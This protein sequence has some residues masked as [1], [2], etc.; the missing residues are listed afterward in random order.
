MISIA[1]I[2]T[3]DAMTH[4]ATVNYKLRVIGLVSKALSVSNQRPSSVTV[5]HKRHT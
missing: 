3:C 5:A 4:D 2:C 1:Y